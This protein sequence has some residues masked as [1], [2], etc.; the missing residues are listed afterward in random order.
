MD[1]I[2]NISH[3]NGGKLTHELIKN[4]FWEHFKNP[5]INGDDSAILSLPTGKTAFTTD[6]FVVSPAFFSGGDI[7]KIAICGTVNDLA[8]MGAR[9]LYIS[10][11][12]II[13]EGYEVNKLLQIAK[14]M[15]AMAKEAGCYIV[16]GDTKVVQKG[17]ADGVF[18]NTSGIGTVEYENLSGTNARVGDSIIVS[19]NIGEHACA[20][21]LE[22]DFKELSAP[23]QSDC[24]PLWDM[25]NTVL[26]KSENIHVMRDPT[27]GG[28]ATTLIEIAQQSDVTIELNQANIPIS[29]PVSGIASLLG[30]DPMFMA[31]EGRM[32]FFV[33]NNEADEIINIIRTHKYGKTAQIIG[34]VTEKSEGQLLLNTLTGVKRR[35]NMPSGLNLPRIC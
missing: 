10:C 16:C 31:C 32:L 30:I 2:I 13:E 1:N 11:G 18:I 3:G 21:M 8:S 6:S 5:Y 33:P 19:G 17:A 35:I 4:V 26:Q 28:I 9:P 29:R 27:R 24:A 23:I 12:F 34:A 15:A 7:G 20:I 25:V 14:S 22:R